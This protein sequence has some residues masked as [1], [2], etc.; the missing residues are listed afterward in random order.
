MPPHPARIRR[1][2]L[3]SF[4][5]ESS[6][7]AEAPDPD[8]HPSQA[9]ERA[10]NRAPCDQPVPEFRMASQRCEVGP[11]E[12]GAPESPEAATCV[13]LHDDLAGPLGYVVIRSR[14]ISKRDAMQW[15][16]LPLRLLQ[17]PLVRILEVCVVLDRRVMLRHPLTND[18]QSLKSVHTGYKLTGI[19]VDLR[20]AEAIDRPAV[21]V[22]F[23]SEA[24]WIQ[25]VL[26]GCL[27]W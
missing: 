13:G 6:R 3:R 16:E 18:V 11:V 2:R 26:R 21:V 24:A 10:H 25:E 19:D 8:D 14:G 12:H 5:S 27:G 9:H 23:H 22:H 17:G 7:R 20:V 15:H 1:N 4:N